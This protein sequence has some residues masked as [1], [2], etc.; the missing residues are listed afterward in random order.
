MMVTACAAETIVASIK[1]QIAGGMTIF[2]MIRMGDSPG[3]DAIMPS[4]FGAGTEK[5]P[6]VLTMTTEEQVLST[7]GVKI[8]GRGRGVRATLAVSAQAARARL[9]SSE[10]F[11]RLFV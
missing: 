8:Q 7:N 3:D 11:M 6:D 10:S 2:F 4:E 5:M 9:T 1:A